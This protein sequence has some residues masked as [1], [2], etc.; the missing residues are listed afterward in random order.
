VRDGKPAVERGFIGYVSYELLDPSGRE[1]LSKLLA[2]AQR[3]GFGKSRSVGFGHVEV[4]PL[5]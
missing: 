4:A 2:F 3:L 1:L 5:E